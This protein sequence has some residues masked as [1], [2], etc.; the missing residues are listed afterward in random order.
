MLNTATDNTNAS[1]E[2]EDEQPTEQKVSQE[3]MDNLPGV[4]IN[5]LEKQDCIL[6]IHITFIPFCMKY[7]KELV[8]KIPPP[9]KKANKVYINVSKI[10]RK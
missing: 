3:K 7:K 9:Q 1:L 8:K 4:L 10:T 6:E 5:A 2:D